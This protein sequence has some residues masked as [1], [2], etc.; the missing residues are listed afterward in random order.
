[1]PPKKYFKEDDENINMFLDGE[2]RLSEDET[3]KVEKR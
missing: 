2:K 1:M 3:A